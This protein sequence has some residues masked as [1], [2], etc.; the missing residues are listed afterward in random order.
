MYIVYKHF[1]LMDQK[2]L[3]ASPFGAALFSAYSY[4]FQGS[5]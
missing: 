4:D 2:W 5:L 3:T 1:P